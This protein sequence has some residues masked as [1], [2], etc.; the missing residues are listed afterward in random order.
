MTSEHQALYGRR[1]NTS[2]IT[3]ILSLNL[4]VN[5]ILN[6]VKRL[7]KKKKN[8]TIPGKYVEYN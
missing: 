2:K 7:I 8:R 3:R 1:Q 4:E 6:N 5:K